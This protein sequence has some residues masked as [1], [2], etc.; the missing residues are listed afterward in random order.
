MECCLWYASPYRV[1]LVVSAAKTPPSR[2]Q[3]RPTDSPGNQPAQLPDGQCVA[4]DEQHPCDAKPATFFD[5]LSQRLLCHSYHV[6]RGRCK[7]LPGRDETEMG[8]R[9]LGR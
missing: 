9:F 1:I 4:S 5:K 3:L 2:K 6:A 7:L 8:R